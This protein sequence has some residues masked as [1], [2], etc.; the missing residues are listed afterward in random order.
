MKVL[1]HEA[2]QLIVYNGLDVVV[3]ISNWPVPLFVLH[4]EVSYKSRN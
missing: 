4:T 3:K 2:R 1:L